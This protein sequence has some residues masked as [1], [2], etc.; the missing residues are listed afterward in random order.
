MLSCLWTCVCVCVH[1][2]VCIWVCV[3][4]HVCVCV[5]VCVCVH[6][7]RVDGEVLPRLYGLAVIKKSE[8]RGCCYLNGTERI[9]VKSKM[10][11][12]LELQDDN[13]LCVLNFTTPQVG[14]V[15]HTHT[16]RH[17]HTYTHTD[18]LSLC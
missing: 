17:T 6:L 4:V 15:I 1:V 8:H 11:T 16:H 5:C 13:K 10:L 2:C 7:Y 14:A 12:G 3:C 9:P 18:M